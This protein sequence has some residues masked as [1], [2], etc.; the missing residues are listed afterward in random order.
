MVHERCQK[1]CRTSAI[2]VHGLKLFARAERCVDQVVSVKVCLVM[3]K[4][5]LLILSCKICN[6]KHYLKQSWIH[7]MSSVIASRFILT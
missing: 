5:D 2:C 7:K 3:L 6:I 4:H 1:I